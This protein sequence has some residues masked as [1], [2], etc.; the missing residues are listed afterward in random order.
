MQNYHELC[1]E[2]THA[3]MNAKDATYFEMIFRLGHGERKG[4]IW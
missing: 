4:P 2:E 1:G 3:F